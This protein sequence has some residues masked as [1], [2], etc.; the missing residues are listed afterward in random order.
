[1]SMLKIKK[2]RTNTVVE[3]FYEIKRNSESFFTRANII[4]IFMIFAS[5]FSPALWIFSLLLLLYLFNIQI[6]ERY[7][8]KKELVSYYLREFSC[9]PA[10]GGVRVF[11]NFG[12]TVDSENEWALH[13]EKLQAYDLPED[14]TDREKKAFSESLA[15]EVKKIRTSQRHR[16][17]GIGKD[18]ITR[19]VIFIGT[20]G[21]GK[22]ETLM[23]WLNDVLK[24]SNSGGVVFI[25]GKADSKMHS[26][27]ASLI[28]QHNRDT[29]SYTISFLKADKMPPTNTYNS[30]LTM[31]PHKAV[32]F[33]GSL[34]GSGGEGNA[35]YF[36]NRGIAM[37]TLP[38]SALRIRSEFYGEP[39][40]L[41]LLQASTSTLNISIL[42]FLFYGMVREQNDILKEQLESSKT[43]N[44]K[45]FSVWQD[46]KDKSTAI[47][48]DMEY[49]E[50]LL[51]YVTQ[52]K[53]SAK[54]DIEE[55]IGYSFRLFYMSYNITFQMTRI[56]TNEI[57]SE[58]G[59]M[60][61]AVAEVVYAHAKSTHNKSFSVNSPNP[62][63]LE[64]IR[65]WVDEIG[66]Q[67][68]FSEATKSKKY[69][70]GK[71]AQI[72][73]AKNALGINEDAKA[74]LSKLPETAV[75]Q[76]AYSQQQWTTLFQAFNEFPN[77]F[78]SPLPD[79]QM[80]D[81]LKNNKV[82]FVMLPAMEL[83]EQ[84]AKLIGQMFIRDMQE[85]GSLSLGGDNL[86]I[87]PTQD[88]LYKDKITPKP[89]S[90]FIADEYGY[91]RVEGSE[92]VMILAQFRSLNMGAVLSLQ[93]VAG[94]GSDEA[95]KKA[96]ANTS[97]L[98]LKSYDREIKEFV[99]SQLAEEDY[100][101]TQKQFN[102][103]G[104][105]VETIGENIEVKQRKTF[106]TSILSDMMYGCGIYIC[107]SKPVIVQ[108][109]YVGGE[110]TEPY[111]SSMEKYQLS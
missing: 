23:S 36:K 109:Y 3:S 7:F 30:I 51:N 39:F 85:T 34:L 63:S 56:Y 38:L 75:Q 93:E 89:L 66:D 71:K 95:T 44:S 104:K 18:F 16:Q 22:T 108:S 28:S 24:K 41:A 82:L 70:D 101:D 6:W 31:S 10:D 14:A 12:Y 102:V 69:Y 49:Y 65:R 97:K 105:I 83:G 90:L 111:I 98:I 4:T 26:K 59:D 55:I 92:M 107:N 32:S 13:Q 2:Q 35:D 40:S 80:T 86:S 87:T 45:L 21:S 96:M 46:A 94:L 84:K 77:V 20:T 88:T 64:D 53:P 78:G 43:Q 27:L 52:Y 11:S 15:L 19:H 25:D 37:L 1:M 47:N 106:D 48:Q 99:D 61:N 73:I 9:P 79:V 67:A 50:K 33:M 17:F 91:Y 29:S 103:N 110:S 57:S 8:K 72:E 100:V 74:T 54:S 60:V 5:I 81:I 76:H 68:V 62:V 42:F 58:W